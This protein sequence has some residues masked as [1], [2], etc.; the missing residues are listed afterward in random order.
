MIATYTGIRLPKRWGLFS[1]ARM[2]VKLLK[3]DFAFA[4]TWWSVSFPAHGRSP[5]NFVPKY[6]VKKI[7][8][9]QQGHIKLRRTT[10]AMIVQLL[11]A[12]A[13]F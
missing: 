2:Q 1:P 4:L 10:S 6:T 13:C 5:E 11:L 7:K 9:G 3:S 12:C 8:Y